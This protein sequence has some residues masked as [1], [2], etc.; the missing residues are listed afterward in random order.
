MSN[1]ANNQNPTYTSAVELQR[2]QIALAEAL[3]RLNRNEDFIKVIKLAYM[4]STLLNEAKDLISTDKDS[5]AIALDKLKAVTYLQSFLEM[6]NTDGLTATEDL[7]D[8][9]SRR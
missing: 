7:F 9:N 2:N 1:K 6:V 8:S 5:V 3:D 4:Q